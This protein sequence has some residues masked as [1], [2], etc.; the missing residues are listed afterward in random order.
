M[1]PQPGNPPLKPQWEFLAPPE[2]AGEL[3]RL[4]Q[5]RILKELGKGGMGIVFQAED[6]QLRRTTALKVLRRQGSAGDETK[7]R[8]LREA[9]AAAALKHDNIVTIYQVGEDR[10]VPFIAMEFLKGKSLEEW[11]RP[12]RRASV[13]EALTIGKQIARGLAAAHAHG[14]IHRDIKPANLWLEAP[15]GRIKILDFGLARDTGGDFTALTQFGAVLG[16]PAFMAPEQARAEVVDQRCDLFSFGCVLYRMVTGRLPFQGSTVYSVLTAVASEAPPAIPELNSQVPERF[17]D[18]INRMLAKKP[19]GRPTSAQ[20][21]L[22]ELQAIEKERQQPA[23][24]AEA[25]TQEF[26]PAPHHSRATGVRWFLV[27]ALLLGPVAYLTWQ[28]NKPATP[29]TGG[30]TRAV[31]VPTAAAPVKLLPL[32]DLR[33]DPVKGDWQLVKEGRLQGRAA[34]ADKVKNFFLTLPWEPPPEYR[35]KLTVTRLVEGEGNLTVDLASGP[36]RFAIRFD[37]VGSGMFH[38]GLDLLEG[39]KMPRRSDPHLGQVLPVGTPVDLVCT[40]QAAKIQI[41]ANGQEIYHWDGD[42]SRL[43]RSGVNPST[44]PLCIGGARSAFYAFENVVLEPVGPNAGKPFDATAASD[45]AN[46]GNREAAKKKK[47][48]K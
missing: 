21:V 16:T 44:V 34:A 40:V 42:V 45:G 1:E 20:A 33:R 8:F 30:E 36:A 46:D 7:A 41:H 26:R 27:A 5:Y 43:S 31:D 3:G 35:L 17:V 19:D 13:A 38:T 48:K 23:P 6:V 11:L 4:A 18:L 39:Q 15:R 28:W 10:G 14:L 37:A 25:T 47:G 32:I 24:A 22:E 29:K 9:R 12:D 2:Q